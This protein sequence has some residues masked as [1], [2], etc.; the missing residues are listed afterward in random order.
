MLIVLGLK[1]R[2]D[3]V[4]RL[5]KR[6]FLTEDWSREAAKQYKQTEDVGKRQRS[7][8]QAGRQQ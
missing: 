2:D 4:A 3:V 6:G 1:H 7:P 5:F 8:M